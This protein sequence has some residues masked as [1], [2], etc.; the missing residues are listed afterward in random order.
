MDEDDVSGDKP[1]TADEID[2]GDEED[3]RTRR[4]AE[5]IESNPVE[6]G[7]KKTAQKENKRKNTGGMTVWWMSMNQ[8]MKS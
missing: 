8:V 6:M 1:V 4:V 5:T 7:K 2:E 3:V